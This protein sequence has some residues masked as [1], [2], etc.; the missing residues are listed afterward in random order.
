MLIV[1]WEYITDA[2]TAENYRSCTLD[3]AATLR[4][5]PRNVKAYYRSA[6]ACLALDKLAEAEDACQHGLDVDAS[7]AALKTLAA[8][9]ANRKARLDELARIR[10][11]QDDRLALEKNALAAALKKR[12]VVV[13][14]SKDGAAPDMEDAIFKLAD[15]VDPD[16]ELSF[17]VLLLYPVDAQSDLIKA[18][19]E[20]DSL[21]QHLEEVL[22]LPW[23]EKGEYRVRDVECYIETS[24]D[25]LVKVGKKLGLGK[26]LGAGKV[27]V[28]DGLVKVNVLPKE[29]VVGWIEEFKRRRDA[30]KG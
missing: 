9:I 10:R 25:G 5:N 23:D 3:C 7:N 11:E 26:V 28:R 17:P 27:E 4:L 20:R 22:P 15:P 18:V 2:Q 29:R 24:T 16:S 21:V 19:G 30:A 1:I 8:R 12:N 14:Y 13:K 6:A